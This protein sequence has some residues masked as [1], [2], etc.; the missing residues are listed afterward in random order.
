MK[1]PGELMEKRKTTDQH[2][3]QHGEIRCEHIYIYIRSS[4]HIECGIGTFASRGIPRIDLETGYL[5][6]FVALCIY[7]YI[8]KVDGVLRICPISTLRVWTEKKNLEY[9]G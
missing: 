1:S 8:Y 9:L 3:L 2:V 7:I 4:T 5:D 6:Y